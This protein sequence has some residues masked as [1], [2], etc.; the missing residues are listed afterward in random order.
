MGSWTQ[1]VSCVVR[2]RRGASDMAVEAVPLPLTQHFSP[3]HQLRQP[4]NPYLHLHHLFSEAGFF[5]L[6]NKHTVH[7]FQPPLPPGY[8]RL[9]TFMRRSENEAASL[10]KV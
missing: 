3:P 6:Q 9:A 10:K 4:S 8:P 2:G 5:V 7:D 1:L